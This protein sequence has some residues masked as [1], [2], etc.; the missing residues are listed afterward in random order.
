MSDFDLD[1][2]P[3]FGQFLSGGSSGGGDANT[4]DDSGDSSGD[5]SG[6]DSGGG[7]SE[8]IPVYCWMDGCEGSGN[9]DDANAGG[10][11]GGDTGDSGG[12]PT[13]APGLAPGDSTVGARNSSVPTAPPVARGGQSVNALAPPGH[14]IYPSLIQWPSTEGQF[15]L[16]SD[17]YELTVGGDIK[18][19]KGWI[20]FVIQLG[21]TVP[22]T[23]GGGSVV[24]FGNHPGSFSG[25]DWRFAKQSVRSTT[26]Y[27]YWDGTAWADVPAAWSDPSNTALYP[28]GIWSEGSANKA[29]MGLTWPEVVPAWGATQTTLRTTVLPRW[30]SQ[31]Q[32]DWSYTWDLKRQDCP[33]LDNQCCRYHPVIKVTFPEV[34]AVTGRVIVL[35][36]NNARSNAGAWSMGDNRPHMPSHEFGHHLGYPDEYVGGVGIDTS[37]NDDGATAGIDPGSMMGVG[38]NADATAV[39]KKRHFRVVCQQL[40]LMVDRASGQCHGYV[41]KAVTGMS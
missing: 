9:S 17:N 2:I 24:N 5:D 26:G 3:I 31:I 23:T 8:T 27:S 19:V 13:E 35:A 18:Y 32:S 38:M 6:D 40:S 10:S 21:A 16:Q 29:Q 39:V 22:A 25:S 7:G 41:F 11:G 12:D 28:I 36:A 37:V 33:S 20:Q 14:D 30:I 15:T 4:G 34:T 1:S